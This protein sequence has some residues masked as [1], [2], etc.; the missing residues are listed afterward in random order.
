ML[1]LRTGSAVLP[2]LDH[3]H[4]ASIRNEVQR[5]SMGNFDETARQ[6]I[7]KRQAEIEIEHPKIA[8][9]HLAHIRSV[10]SNEEAHNIELKTFEDVMS[11]FQSQVPDLIHYRMQ[12]RITRSEASEIAQRLDFFPAIRSAVRA[13][14]YMNFICIVHGNRPGFDKLDDYR[15]VIECSYC[16]ALITGDNQLYRTANQINPDIE[17]VLCN[18]VC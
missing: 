7:G 5:L 17:M 13:D 6:F 14:L 18:E 15:H 12:S 8:Q 1:K 16:D 4:Q 2:F 10:R 9:G 3:F 11:Y